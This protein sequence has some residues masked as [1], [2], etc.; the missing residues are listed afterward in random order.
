[1]TGGTLD[2]ATAL[3]YGMLNAVARAGEFPGA[4][5]RLAE[6]L[7]D[8]PATALGLIKRS[9]ELALAAPLQQSLDYEAEAQ[10]IAGSSAEY[11]EGVRAFREK[12]RPQFR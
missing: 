3:S 7:A 4:V 6:R 12:R 1:M 10:E 5:R 9:F 2:A 8:G 11:A